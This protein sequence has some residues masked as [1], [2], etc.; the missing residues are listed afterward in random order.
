MRRD[1]VGRRY[2]QSSGRNPL[3]ARAVK[4]TTSRSRK[5]VGGSC[6]FLDPQLLAD[7][8]FNVMPGSK[9]VAIAPAIRPHGWPPV[10]DRLVRGKLV[11]LHAWIATAMATAVHGPQPRGSRLQ[12]S[13]ICGDERCLAAHHIKYQSKDENELDKKFHREHNIGS[14]RVSTTAGSTG[15][16]L[17]RK[18]RENRCEN[19]CENEW[20]LF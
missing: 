12:A 14:F 2:R 6:I 11:A 18:R 4:R 10:R 8:H 20:E 3:A 7:R 5:N 16:R 17:N 1:A 13:H 9:Y 15:V 19:R